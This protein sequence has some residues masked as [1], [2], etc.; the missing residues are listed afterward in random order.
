MTDQGDNARICENEGAATGLTAR[1]SL[2]LETAALN[3]FQTAA[4]LHL[5]ATL[6]LEQLDRVTVWAYMQ[7]YGAPTRLLDWTESL[8]VAAYFAAEKELTKSILAE[9]SLQDR[10]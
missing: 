1:E 5:P 3:E 2:T 6:Q 10:G 4:H 9:S 8:Y 7:H